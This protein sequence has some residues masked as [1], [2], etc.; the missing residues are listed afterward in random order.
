MAKTLVAVVEMIFIIREARALMN[1]TSE[2]IDRLCR[3]IETF[4]VPVKRLQDEESHLEKIGPTL[5]SL[6]DALIEAHTFVVKYKGGTSLWKKFL[7][8]SFRKAYYSDLK[9][10]NQRLQ[11]CAV[12]LQ[13]SLVVDHEV[14]RREDFEAFNCTMR[15]CVDD[16]I[17]R[18]ASTSTAESTGLEEGAATATT[19]TATTTTA[20]TTATATAAATTTATAAAATTAATTT[21]TA[22]AAA[23]VSSRE[24]S[25]REANDFL[26]ELKYE[27]AANHTLL[28]DYLMAQGHAKLSEEE[29]ELQISMHNEIVDKA[30]LQFDAI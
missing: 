4:E 30:K 16:A 22:T 26:A 1:E 17:S 3:R 24:I 10:I 5:S 12:D 9:G 11:Q 19:T 20:A 15:R 18:V 13:F 14:R 2:E 7:K 28:N 27:L 6:E 25:S 21:A 8:I 29:I 23:A